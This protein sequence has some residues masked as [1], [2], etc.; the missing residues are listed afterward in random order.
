MRLVQ[1][2]GVDYV[3][4]SLG[5]LLN[6]V[7]QF[8]PL[9]AVIVG[10]TLVELLWPG[11]RYSLKSRVAGLEFNFLGAMLAGFLIYPVT[12]LSGLVFGGPLIS[13]AFLPAPV[14]VVAVIVV[15]D[16]LK[17]WEHRF[18][19][20]FAWPIHA[21]HH[22][23]E[24]LHGAN[25][26]AHPF[27]RVIEMALIYVPLSLID[28]GSQAAPYFVAVVL[29]LQ[30]Q[31]I[32]SSTR[33]HLGPLRA[34]FVDNVSHRYHHSDK[35]E[36]FDK[37]FGVIFTVWDR[38]FGTWHAP[39][40]GE[41]LSFGVKEY[42]EARSLTGFLALPFIRLRPKTSLSH[43]MSKTGPRSSEPET[44]SSHPESKATSPL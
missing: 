14:A 4:Y 34:V 32:H 27:A 12:W 30:A 1:V 40:K 44:S 8:V 9:F 23:P 3:I 39:V 41:A 28:F 26:Y 33:L 19:H 2:F 10:I 38:L 25:S 17:Y 5:F 20:R 43:L 35:P 7:R 42:P 29:L 16:F 13:L 11:E 18:E 31:A 21:V 24:E 36:H 22:S 6:E 37:N 15:T